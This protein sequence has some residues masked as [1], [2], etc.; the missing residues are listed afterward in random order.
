MNPLKMK[1]TIHKTRMN[2]ETGM[3]IKLHLMQKNRKK[4][5]QKRIQIISEQ[6]LL[7]LLFFMVNI[8]LSIPQH[9]YLVIQS[10]FYRKPRKVK[11]KI[12]RN[13]TVLNDGSIIRVRREKSTDESDE[14]Y[15]T[16]T[17]SDEE[18]KEEEKQNEE[19]EATQEEPIKEKTPEPEGN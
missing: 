1:I 14:E 13:A 12:V 11:K 2:K 3:K 6:V 10:S 8:K 5:R 4:K 17:S 18:N 16:D 9:F 15:Y 7:R 19:A